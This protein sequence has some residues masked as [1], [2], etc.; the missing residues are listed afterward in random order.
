M[1]N[2]YQR[3]SKNE[4]ME[5]RNMY[6]ATLKGKEMRLR[7]IRLNITGT[8]GLLIAIYMIVNGNYTKEIQ[9]YDY[10]IAI[11]LFLASFTFLIGAYIIRGKVLNQFAIKIPRFRNK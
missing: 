7:L 9:W 10:C 4:K 8:L 11:S 2:K 1:K 6:Y 5:C 3:L